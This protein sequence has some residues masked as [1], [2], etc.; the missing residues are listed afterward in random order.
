MEHEWRSYNLR[1]KIPR[2]SHDADQVGG[3]RATR[4]LQLPYAATAFFMTTS[5]IL[6]WLVSQALFVSGGID[7]FPFEWSQFSGVAVIVWSPL[8]LLIIGLITFILLLATTIYYIWP[9]YTVMPVMAGSARVVLDACCQLQEPLPMSG[10]QWGDISSDKEWIAG[11][12]EIV[13][14]LKDGVTYPAE[15]EK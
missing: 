13:G 11:F 1:R 7:Q 6:H 8:A 2:I 10:I 3:V 9:F 14:E 5:T 12:G 15:K 4:F